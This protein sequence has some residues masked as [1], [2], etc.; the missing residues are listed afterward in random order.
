MGHFRLKLTVAL[1]MLSYCAQAQFHDLAV[2]DDGSR[3]IFA[4][5]L[6]LVSETS[7]NLPSGAAIYAI[8][9]GAIDRL[10]VPP[11]Y[12][13]LP[14]HSSSQG[15]PQVSADG[16]VFSYTQYSNCGGGSACITYPSTS[17][18]FLTVDGRT[19]DQVLKGEAQISRNGR[20]VLNYLTTCCPIPAQPD[21]IQ[22]HDLQTGT[23]VQPPLPPAGKRQAVT[24]AGTVLLL[25]RRNGSLVIR[26]PQSSLALSTA[27]PPKSGI[28]NDLGTWVVY[29]AAGGPQADLRAYEIATGRDVL[30]ASRSV[31]FW[32]SPVF[33]SSISN[34]GA[35]V[36]YL[37]APQP[38]LP[39]QAWTIHPDG[40]GRRQ[41][42]NFP[43]DV[44]EAVL[45]GDGQTA[46][47]ATGGRLVSIDVA[48]G[49]V[50]ELIATTPTCYPGL[51][52]ITPG[53]L[54]PLKGTALA[55]STQAASVPL[56][57]ELAGA[58]VLKDGSPLPLLSVSPTEIWFQVPWEASP[59]ATA[60]LTVNHSSPFDACSVAIPISARDP[61]LFAD[62]TGSA[63]F[64]HQDFS[65][66]V[67]PESPAQAG[68]VV[69]AY[70]LGLGGVS[71]SVPTGVL[72]PSDQLYPL[73]WPFACYQGS[74]SDDGPP[75]D[76]LFAGLA[77]AMIGIYQVNI[78]M[79][80]PLPSGSELVLNCG[81]PGNIY[82]RGGAYIP[83]AAGTP[84]ARSG[85]RPFVWPSTGT[86]PA[87][88]SHDAPNALR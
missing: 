75:L 30:L 49:S 53:S 9:N 44:S 22:L 64:I 10:T 33:D 68:E 87:E 81:T 14:F 3:A 71:P 82:E 19:S 41:L 74:A 50:R 17:T 20:F 6:R 15:N 8:A 12:N 66:I 67:T 16:R 61:N 24:S 58:R 27:E 37:A 77:P 56:P 34:D 45:S 78:R 55:A 46:I 31:E 62:S 72:T 25:D 23:T 63:I 13:P 47:A 79:P 38:G 21:L 43:Q 65:G 84:A 73:N 48:T 32:Y 40:T 70:A 1:V 80:D 29:E 11:G 2:A 54:F 36:L 7:Q 39:F 51:R 59:G 85:T 28:V 57:A 52:S 69:T 42:T 60:A 26:T 5:S 76:V 83:I 18:S 4:T 88:S 86:V 35:T